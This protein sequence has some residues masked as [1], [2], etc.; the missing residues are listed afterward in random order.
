MRIRRVVVAL[1]VATGFIA[2]TAASCGTEAKES[3][4]QAGYE[5]LRSELQASLTAANFTNVSVVITKE[6]D[7]VKVESTSTA[8]GKRDSKPNPSASATAGTRGQQT[9]AAS[10]KP[11][12]TAVTYDILDATFDIPGLTCR[13]NAEQRL[14]PP[15]GTPQLDELILPDGTEKEIPAAL[16]GSLNL[17]TIFDYAFVQY[18]QCRQPNVTAPPVPAGSP[19]TQ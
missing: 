15:L 4:K 13:G 17:A 3:A 11:T 5:V 10:P 9:K 16:R 6:T 1:A 14:T 8:G 7:D 12:T 2:T 19:A 18:P